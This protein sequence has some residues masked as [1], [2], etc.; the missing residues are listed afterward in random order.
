[1]KNSS[2][3]R[4][5]MSVIAK[6]CPGENPKIPVRLAREASGMR[7]EKNKKVRMWVG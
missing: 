1:M 3:F 4:S 7:D 2:I 5:N 6:N